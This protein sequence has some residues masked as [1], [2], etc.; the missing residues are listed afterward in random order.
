MEVQRYID[1]IQG[2]ITMKYINESIEGY[3]GKNIPYTLYGKTDS[4]HDLVIILPGAGYTANSPIFHYSTGVFFNKNKDILAVNYSYSDPFYN[5]FSQNE[6]Y[7]AVKSDSKLV[8][9]KIL[10]TNSYINFYII[11]KSIGTIAMSSELKR[12]IFENAK[13]PLLDLDEVFTTMV[14]SKNK[15]LCFMGD[16]DRFYTEEKFNKIRTNKN[17]T[18]KLIPGVNHSLDHEE[19]IAKSIDTLKDVVTDIEKF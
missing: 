12:T 11:G 13:T 19:D 8:I 17:I 3:K 18:S 9:D 1:F 14:D 2:G 16:R 4:S 6:L 10:N 5:N 7:E 15:G